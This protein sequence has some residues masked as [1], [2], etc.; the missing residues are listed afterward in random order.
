M[1]RLE[2][3]ILLFCLPF[4]AFAQQPKPCANTEG[5]SDWL[6]AYQKTPERFE[7]ND[8]T[9][10]QIPLTIHNVGT[11][12]ETAFLRSNALLDAL[13]TLNQDFV[14]AKMNFYIEGDIN[15]IANTAYYTH[16]TV[17]DGA[18]MMFANNISNTLN[19]YVV[20]DPAG[21]C[22]YNLPYAGIALNK[23]CVRPDDHTWAHE[24]GHAFK[25]PHPFLGWEGGV[26]HDNSVEHNYDDPAPERVLLDYT[27]FK[28]TLILDT[29]IIDTVWV[30]TVERNNCHFAADGFCDT[31]ADYLNYRWQCSSEGQS[32]VQQTDPMGARFTSDASLIM[33]YSLDECANRF[34]PEQIAAMRA[35]L[36]DTKSNWLYN[37]EPLPPVEDIPVVVISPL[38]GEITPP[39]NTYFEWEVVPNTTHYVFE[40]SR[41]ASFAVL[42]MDTIVSSNSLVVDDLLEGRN[43][44]WRI[45]AFNSHSFC[46]NISSRFSFQTG[47][48]SSVE[49]ILR[50]DLSVYPNIL[51][52][53]QSVTLE[54]DAS[55]SQKINIRIMN[56]NGRIIQNTQQRIRVG[57]NRIILQILDLS[58]GV[59]FIQLEGEHLFA[60]SK[61]LIH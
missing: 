9:I 16:E 33:S 46:T 31:E 60:T 39:E 1:Y 35:N 2:I 25:L 37:Q 29:L 54:F 55:S 48:L 21:A 51:T 11:N 12:A 53:G 28:D 8:S 14:Q 30:E 42:Q 3:L 17:L 38:E 26:N 7:K 10:F 24:V 34:S 50:Q 23:G 43:Y 59:Y 36:L 56:L 18:E 6:K 52:T 44:Y 13:C 20:G 41:L 22:G 15:R 19:C 4:L 40:M 61:L 58:S 27:Y 45:R 32:T 5:R 47:T 49:S 57:E